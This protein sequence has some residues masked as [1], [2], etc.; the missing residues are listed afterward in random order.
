MQWKGCTLDA[1]TWRQTALSLTCAG[2]LAVLVAACGT[3]ATDPSPMPLPDGP[4]ALQ[5]YAAPAQ[6]ALWWEMTR[7]CSGLDRDVSAVKW[8]SEPADQLRPSDDGTTSIAGEWDASKN[9]ITLISDAVAQP[10]IVQ[11]EMLHALLVAGGHP[12][13]K[14]GEDCASYVNCEGACA[15]S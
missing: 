2:T 11:H 9:S 4:R 8:Y 14:F 12:A 6:Y 1:R 15:R 10:A 5:P 13:D 7:S 3:S